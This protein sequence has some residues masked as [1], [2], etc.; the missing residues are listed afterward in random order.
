[1]AVSY[2]I[3]NG[4]FQPLYDGAIVPGGKV[5]FYEGGTTTPLDTYADSSQLAANTNPVILN[6]QGYASIYLKPNDLYKVRLDS[7]ADVTLWTEDNIRTPLDQ[8]SIQA[9]IDTS[10]ASTLPFYATKSALE[11]AT[12]ASGVDRVRILGFL[13]E[14]DEGGGE[15]VRVSAQ[16][17]HSLRIRSTDRQLPD[18][19]GTDNTNGGWWEWAE[20]TVTPFA[21]G[22]TGDG[23][24][25]DAAVIDIVND[26]NSPA[27]KV[28]LAG[29]VW[30]YGGT[31]V[32]ASGIHLINGAVVDDAETHSFWAVQSVDGIEAGISGALDFSNLATDASPANTD[33]IIMDVSGVLKRVLPDD[34]LAA[35]SLS[36]G[37]GFGIW[38]QTATSGTGGGAPSVG[39]NTR[40]IN[41]EEYNA[42]SGS[43][44]ASNQI[45]LPAGTY[46]ARYWAIGGTG[47]SQAHQVRLYNVTAAT[48]V[49]GSEG[50]SCFIGGDGND[51]WFA[52]HG[53]CIFTLG[54][55][56]AIRLE[57][58]FAKVQA[59]GLGAATSSGVGEKYAEIYI[60]RLA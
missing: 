59:N 4:K 37:S 11:A 16:P 31:F 5:Y 2:H 8:A 27:K 48:A 29:R 53:T 45:T 13:T 23:V 24:T 30:E 60:Q 44:L 7:S 55:S 18:G 47:A 3:T 43:S 56:Q 46:L 19:G 57:H 15:Y 26:N 9:L 34:A 50:A 51:A 25:D 41:E 32:R 52:S 12:V 1:M 36:G 14:E 38:S 6:A 22:G 35:A 20:A 39:W 33:Y 10:V 54:A 42:I 40:A 17:S 21:A 28:D 49:T 58:Y